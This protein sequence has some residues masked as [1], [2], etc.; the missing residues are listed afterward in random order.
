MVFVEKSAEQVASI[1][2]AWLAVAD[3]TQV[4]GWIRRFQS[5]RP[6]GTVVVVVGDVDL[7][8]LLQVTAPNDQ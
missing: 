7:E 5:E 1:H 6:V 8:Y 4:G 3:D 2:P